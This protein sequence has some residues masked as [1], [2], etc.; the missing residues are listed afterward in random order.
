LPEKYRKRRNR[1]MKATKRHLFL[2]AALVASMVAAGCTTTQSPHRQANDLRITA[3]VKSKLAEEVQPSSLVNIDVNT[4]NGV[5][6][7]SGQVETMEVRNGAEMVAH[8]VPGVVRVNNNLQV[9]PLPA[10]QARR[11]AT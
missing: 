7:L 1:N 6:T 10:S 4:T 9:E 2:F 5:V 11:S 8:R 3:E